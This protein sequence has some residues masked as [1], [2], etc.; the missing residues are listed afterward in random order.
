MASQPVTFTLEAY[1]HGTHARAGIIHTPHGDIETPAFVPVGTLGTVKSLRP[2]DIREKTAARVMLSNTYHLFLQP[3]HEVV[4]EGGGLGAF[5][6]WQ[7]PT[8]TDSGGFQIFSLGA[9]MGENVT[10]FLHEKSVPSGKGGLAVYDR[11]HAAAHGKLCAVDEDGVTFTS[12]RDG[13][14]HRFTAERSV[15][16]QHALGADIIIAFDECPP[17]NASRA[18]E[19]EAM[20]RTHRWA[21]RSLLAHKRNYRALTTQ[22]LYGVVQG[23]RFLDLRRE[24]ARTIAAMDFD[25]FCIGGSFEK[26][27]LGKPIEA[28]NALLPREKPRHLL[29]IGE[30]E[31]I[32]IGVAMGCDT[33]DCVAPTRLARNGT[34]YVYAKGR[35]EKTSLLR[36]RYQADHTRLDA[37]CTCHTCT[38]FTRAYLAHLFRSREMLGPHLLTIH[39]LHAIVSFTHRLR[40][41]ILARGSKA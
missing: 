35:L 38:H 23:G 4:R 10:K 19:E 15:E 12:H 20:A 29:G 2:D 31:D 17:P 5:S 9:G 37:T 1:L 33:F 27:S 24:S 21:K 13:S 34:A 18:Y 11:T 36:S 8:M 14:M 16:I 30:P 41:D 6:G 26:A 39:N 28:A 3:G 7:G 22:G 32:E 40:Q 25:G